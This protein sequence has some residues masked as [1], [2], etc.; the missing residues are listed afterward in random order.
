MPFFPLLLEVPLQVSHEWKADNNSN[1]Q[2]MSKKPPDAGFVQCRCDVASIAMDISTTPRRCHDAMLASSSA[3]PHKLPL[4]TNRQPRK[5]TPPTAPRSYRETR[6]RAT[7]EIERSQR[8][9]S[10]DNVRLPNRARI[11]R[12][13]RRL[14]DF[15]IFF[16]CLESGPG[17]RKSTRLFHMQPQHYVDFCCSPSCSHDWLRRTTVVRYNPL[18]DQPLCWVAPTKPHV[19]PI[20]CTTWRSMLRRHH[21]S[22]SPI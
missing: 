21:L 22:F 16:A 17:C 3:R 2:T 14:F 4:S 19:Y 10:T 12:Y 7:N 6:R 5:S 11:A 13:L 20:H 8:S 1:T 9:G 18:P 15:I